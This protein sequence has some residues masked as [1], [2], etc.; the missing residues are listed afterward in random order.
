MTW[1]HHHADLGDV[2]IHYVT[3]GAGDAIV[4]LHGWPQTWYCW[5]NVIRLLADRYRVVAPDLRGLGDSVGPARYDKRT[6]AGDVLNLMRDE[7]GI[8]RFHVVGH[9][10]GGVTAYSLAAHHPDAVATLTVVD[11]TVPGAGTTDI[12][13]GGNRWHHGF[14]R[15]LQLPEELVTGREEIYLGRFYRNFGHRPLPDEDIREYLRTYTDPESGH[16]V[17]E[18]R[19]DALVQHLVEFIE[20][21]S[22]A[23]RKSRDHRLHD[24]SDDA[25]TAPFP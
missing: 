3:A 20:R 21:S 16:W 5:R 23:G 11:V 9:D 14:H 15:T 12:A 13:Q 8:G 6:L 17:P 25:S 2:R 22:S 4:L 19:P 10:W 24:G 18:E 1:Q 7:L